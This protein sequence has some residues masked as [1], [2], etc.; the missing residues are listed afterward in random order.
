MDC[1]IVTQGMKIIKTNQPATYRILRGDYGLHNRPNAQAISK[2]VKKF[3]E[4]RVVTNSERPAS[5]R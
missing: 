5:F 4:T 1:L 3:E 2:I